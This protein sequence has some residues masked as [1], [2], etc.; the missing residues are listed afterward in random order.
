MTS[1]RTY[2]LAS[3]YSILTAGIGVSLLWLS[4]LP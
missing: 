2:A 3:W 1:P 4:T